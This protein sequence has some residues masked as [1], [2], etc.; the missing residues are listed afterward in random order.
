MERDAL[1]G[2]ITGEQAGVLEAAKV[3]L[4][5]KGKLRVFNY[6]PADWGAAATKWEELGISWKGNAIS[7][8]AADRR[9]VTHLQMIIRKTREHKNKEP[10]NKMI[11]GKT[12]K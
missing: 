6:W 3:Y 7:V 2:V 1:C 12:I 10:D 9:K 11:N 4:R 5:S 8:Y